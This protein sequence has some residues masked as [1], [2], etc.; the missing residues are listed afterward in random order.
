MRSILRHAIRILTVIGLVLVGSV[1]SVLANHSFPDVA[2]SS[3]FHDDIARFADAECADGFP[4][5]GFHP[6][7]PVKRQQMARFFSRCGGSVVGST[8]NGVASATSGLD[9][10]AVTL[11][12]TP[13]ASGFVL[14]LGHMD[15]EVAGEGSCGCNVVTTIRADSTDL[16]VADGSVSNVADSDGVARTSLSPS[17]VV[18]VERGTPVTFVLLGRYVDN[19]TGLVVSMFGRMQLL[20]VPFAL[21]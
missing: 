3:P 6:T 19:N 1:G 14:A 13:P 10:D 8:E 12:V 16:A 21:A 9:R 7:D 20:F 18:A 2:D 15:F 4:D 11:T 5:G 17:G